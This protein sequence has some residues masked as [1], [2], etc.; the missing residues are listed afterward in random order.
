MSSVFCF[1]FFVFRFLF[2]VI[3]PSVSS[4]SVFEL[5]IHIFRFLFSIIVPSVHELPSP[6]TFSDRFGKNVSM[7]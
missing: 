6:L 1:L 3:V 5:S 4:F 2:S 7:I